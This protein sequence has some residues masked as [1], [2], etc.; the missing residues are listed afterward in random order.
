M[1]LNELMSML[2]ESIS[3]KRRIDQVVDVVEIE[4]SNI[5]GVGIDG[6]RWLVC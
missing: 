5:V 2:I 3:L 1:P 4:D 6:C